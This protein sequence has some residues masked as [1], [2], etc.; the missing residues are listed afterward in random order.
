MPSRET[1]PSLDTV[2]LVL[3]RD[4]E[5]CVLCLCWVA[6]GE[7]GKHWVIHHRRPRAMGGTRRQSTNYPSNLVT[8]CRGCHDHVE[9]ER[10]WARDEG[11]ILW[12]SQ[13]PA[14]EPIH[15]NQGWRLLGETGAWRPADPPEEAG[16]AA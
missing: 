14:R 12:Q 16:D 10:A 11:L 15:H 2:R 13:D 4:R 8:L 5:R 9:K 3:E 6:A 7:R 1:G